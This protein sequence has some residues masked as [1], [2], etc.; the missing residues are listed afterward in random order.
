MQNLDGH[1]VGQMLLALGVGQKANRPKDL[2]RDLFKFM[3]AGCRTVTDDLN[4][5]NTR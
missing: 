2:T 4:N 5:N 3:K 1:A